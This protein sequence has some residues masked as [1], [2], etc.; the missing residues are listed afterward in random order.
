MPRVECIYLNLVGRYLSL[1]VSLTRIVLQY[2]AQL[3][4]LIL[5]LITIFKKI[6][7]VLNY[8]KF[9]I[10]KFLATSLAAR[11]T[12]NNVTTWSLTSRLIEQS[13]L[14][15]LLFALTK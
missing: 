3:G 10:C 8:E 2:Y 15:Y 6:I 12:Q 7:F 13:G 4:Q 5:I 11:L 14:K 9:K 1:V